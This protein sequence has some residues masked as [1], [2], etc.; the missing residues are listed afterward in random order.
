MY[1]LFLSS[2]CL[3]GLLSPGVCVCVWTQ[4]NAGR[5]ETGRFDKKMREVLRRQKGSTARAAVPSVEGR[6]LH[7]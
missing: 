7:V 1:T 6:N 3:P 4:A 2:F 5:K